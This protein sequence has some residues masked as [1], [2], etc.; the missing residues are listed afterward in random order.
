MFDSMSAAEVQQNQDV[1]QVLTD[2]LTLMSREKQVILSQIN[3]LICFR[4]N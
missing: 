4:I 2:G 1:A 3:L